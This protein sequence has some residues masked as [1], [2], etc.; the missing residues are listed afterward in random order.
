MAAQASEGHVVAGKTAISTD[1]DWVYR[2]ASSPDSKF[3]ALIGSKGRIPDAVYSV[4][5][6]DATTRK[7]IQVLPIKR[8]GSL[9]G[10]IAFSPDGKYLAAGTGIITLWDAHTWQP[11]RDIQGPYE[12]GLV[13]SG[14]ESFAFAPDGRS[15]AVL[16]KSVVWPEMITIRT[17]E[18][19]AVWAKKEEA[20]RK[21]GTY[22][23]KLAK[24]EILSRLATIMA[25]HVETEKRILSKQRKGA[26]SLG[27]SGYLQPI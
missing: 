21:D 15:L 14:V 6:Y 20:A 18:E 1:L 26:L 8:P 25:F 17:K 22:S 5:V 24:G 3:F 4:L 13:S 10:E 23:E 12:R 19:A 11:V 16:Y 27:N 9:L 2:A 7:V